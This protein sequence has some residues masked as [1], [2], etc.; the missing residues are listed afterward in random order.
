MVNLNCPKINPPKSKRSY[1]FT[2]PQ[3]QLSLEEIYSNCK[4]YFENDKPY[5]LLK[6]LLNLMT[7]M[8]L[9]K[10]LMVLCHLMI[11]AIKRLNNSTLTDIFVMSINPYFRILS[12][13]KHIFLLIVVL[14]L[15]MSNVLLT[16]MVF[17]VA[18]S[19]LIF[20]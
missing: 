19:N 5:F 10:L 17:L 4:S 12:L 16:K 2:I 8:I 18:L 13:R 9:I 6:N 14:K 20:L 3:K 15:K 7:L 11:F 1:V